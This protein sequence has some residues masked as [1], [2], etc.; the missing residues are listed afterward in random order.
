MISRYEQQDVVWVDLENPTVDEVIAVANEFEL[1]SLLL[2]ELLTP[3]AKPRVDVYPGFVYAIL[4]FPAMRYT[5]GAEPDHEIDIIMG[6]HFIITTHYA[7]GSAT[8]DLGKAFEASSLIGEKKGPTLSVGLI[9]L[10]LAQR[11]YQAADNEL[12]SLEDTIRDIEENIFEGKEKEMV[13]A[14]SIASRELFTH[15]RLLGTHHDILDSLE[16]AVASL[17]GDAS[18]YVRGANALHYR[19]H[20]RALTMNDVLNELRETNM[21]LLSTRQNEIMKNLTI[22]AFVT[23]PLTLIAAVFGMNTVNT[24]VVGA[25]QDFLLIL[26]GMGILTVLLFT[27]FKLRKWF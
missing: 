2:D 27:Y 5:H 25:P 17:F 4:H 21:A 19:V 11:L 14:I 10:E 7:A 12:D 16:K 6:K 8:Y 15:K 13:S 18:H 1:G 24:P 3:T 23:F 20:S 22:M 26:G 9:F